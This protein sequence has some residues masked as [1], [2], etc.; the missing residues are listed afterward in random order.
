MAL[1]KELKFVGVDHEAMR[2]RLRV[3][4]AAFVARYFECNLVLDDEKRGL[5]ERGILLRLRQR[6]G[7][8]VLTVK[9]P[10]KDAGGLK[11]RAEHE[12]VVE[13]HDDTLNA[14]QALGYRVAFA[15]EKVREKWK[16]GECTI[17]LDSLPFGD[18]VELEGG[19]GSVLACAG[20]LNLAMSSASKATY[21]ALNAAH[22]EGQGLEPDENFVFP[23]EVRERL[24]L[25]LEG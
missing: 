20:E 23:E 2:Q 4:D 24:I 8:S 3:L 15:Y 6:Q 16:L 13:S 22:R 7:V 21:H 18:F 17:C 14:L 5:K 25:E 12:T 9:E 10:V 1:E 11:V 19:E